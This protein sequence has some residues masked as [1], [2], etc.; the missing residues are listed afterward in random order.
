LRLRD[1]SFPVDSPS[2]PW[3]SS[4]GYSLDFDDQGNPIEGPLLDF[5]VYNPS[6]AWGAGN[7]VSDEDDLASF[8]R[9]LFGG[10]LLAPEQLAEMTTGFAVEPGV[11][12]Y[13]LGLIIYETDCGP[14]LGHNGGIPGFLNDL[15]S[16]PDGTHQFGLM[17]NVETAPQ[18]VGAP[19]SAAL[20]QALSEAFGRPCR[21]AQTSVAMQ[22]A[23]A[24]G[25]R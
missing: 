1:T 6:P 5:T 23:A 4:R 20:E 13:G 12:S 17:I 9:A 8:Y 22:E 24:G 3:P 25:R 16:S 11:A 18:A 14:V 21:F 7:I 10:E 2:L 19:Y 15:Y